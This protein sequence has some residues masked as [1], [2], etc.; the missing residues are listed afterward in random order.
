LS[1]EKKSQ[2]DNSGQEQEGYKPGLSKLL[3]WVAF[4]LVIVLIL[5]I[6]L[7]SIIWQ[8]QQQV[9]KKGRKRMSIL[10]RA[11]QYYYQMTDRYL[12]DPLLLMNAVSA[13]RDSTRA[14]SNFY[15]ER[16]IELNDT[17]LSLNVP[18]R[19]YRNFDTTF[20]VSYQKKDTVLD[21][22]YT[23]IK[24]NSELLA[25]DT[26]FVPSGNLNK[27]DFDSILGMDVTQRVSTNTYYHPYYLDSVF[28]FRPLIDKKY[29]IQA[30][31]DS[32]K[33]LDPID[34]IYKEPRFL[35][36]SFKD[37]SHGVIKNGEKSWK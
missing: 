28:A 18:K 15:G 22:T 31:T 10:S 25:Y 34:G 13:A 16:K 27:M 36:F 23:I 24:W 21:S 35:V 4:I 32:Y 9:R 14:D 11:E 30:D 2:S 26:L 17:V 20:A 5:V 1:E 19:F 8:D 12:E 6:Y 33:I 7:P 3:N 37:S 29:V